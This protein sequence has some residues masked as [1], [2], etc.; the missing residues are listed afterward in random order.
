MEDYLGDFLRLINESF[1]YSELKSPGNPS[2]K[3]EYN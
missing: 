3:I 2:R 1:I